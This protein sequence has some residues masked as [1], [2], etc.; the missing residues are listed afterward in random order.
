MTRGTSPVTSTI[1][2]GNAVSAVSASE[3]PSRYTRTESP[4]CRSASYTSVAAGLPLMFADDT[5]SGPVRLSSS[6][7]FSWSGTRS[8]TVPLVSPRSH[9]S[10]VCARQI[11]VSAPGQNASHSARAASLTEVAS[12][13]SVSTAEISTGGGMSRPRPFA[14]SSRWTASGLNASAAMPYT[15][16]VGNTTSWPSRIAST[17]AEYDGQTSVPVKT[18][19]SLTTGIVPSGR[20]E[21]PAPP[22]EPRTF[23]WSTTRIEGYPRA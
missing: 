5:A 2:D 15:V 13:S 6:R 18:K 21:G 3:P 8:A 20:S 4:S 23:A 16:S 14:S 9:I 7:V 19:R 11:T 1:V 17:A 22:R 12:A 10:D